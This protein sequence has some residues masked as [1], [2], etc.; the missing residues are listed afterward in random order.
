M[1]ITFDHGN[2]FRRIA[3]LG[4]KRLIYVG[5]ALDAFVLYSGQFSALEAAFSDHVSSVG[6]L[7]DMTIRSELFKLF[8]CKETGEMDFTQG[9]QQ[10]TVPLFYNDLKLSESKSAL[11]Q[12]RTA[13]MTN[14]SINI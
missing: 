1:V 14:L 5:M 7:I 4:V 9:C 3:G 11:V 10:K 2:Y 13:L 6:I 12:N 8:I